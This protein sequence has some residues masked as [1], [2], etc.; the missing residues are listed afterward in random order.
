MQDLPIK[1]GCCSSVCYEAMRRITPACHKRL[2]LRVCGSA[3]ERF[4]FGTSQRCMGVYPSCRLLAAS[5]RLPA[6]VG[7]R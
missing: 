5:E 1:T 6:G 4:M 3:V 7:R 2:H